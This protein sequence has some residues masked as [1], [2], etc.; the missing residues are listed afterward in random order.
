MV[1]ENQEGLKHKWTHYLLLYAEDVDV[2]GQI[3]KAMK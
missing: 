2:M 1:Q 3:A